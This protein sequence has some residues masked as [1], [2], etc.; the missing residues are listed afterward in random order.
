MSGRCIEMLDGDAIDALKE[1]RSLLEDE[2]T[3]LAFERDSIAQTIYDKNKR[4]H[5]INETIRLQ[6]RARA[7]VCPRC[8]KQFLT[9]KRNVRYCSPKCQ[10]DDNKHKRD[11]SGRWM[12]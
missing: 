8:G 9:T 4:L 1:E 6:S 5:E 11:D 12:Y 7:V 2:L 10:D 3:K